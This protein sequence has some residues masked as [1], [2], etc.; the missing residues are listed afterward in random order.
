MLLLSGCCLLLQCFCYFFSFRIILFL[1]CYHL[2]IFFWQDDSGCT[3]E[4][5]MCFFCEDIV[6]KNVFLPV[7]FLMIV[8]PRCVFVNNFNNKFVVVKGVAFPL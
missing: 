7:N 4:G 8:D 3:S 1:S 6:F 2:D 5:M